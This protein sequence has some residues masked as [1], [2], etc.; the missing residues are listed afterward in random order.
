MTPSSSGNANASCSRDIVATVFF[1]YCHA[2]EVLRDQLQKHLSAM[3]RQ[4]LIE[5]WY[6]R[7]IPA[8]DHIDHSIMR[9][10]ERADVVLLLVSPDFL[11]SDYCNDVEVRRALERHDAG[12]CRVIPVILRH[13][14]WHG[15][16]FGK[17]N[18]TPKDGKPVR[19]F[20]D[21]DEGFLQVVQAIKA[22]LPKSPTQRP[23]PPQPAAQSARQAGASP[24]PRSSNLGLPRKL[25][26]VDL[27]T[28]RDKTFDFIAEYFANSLRE[29]EAR[30][31]QVKGRFTRIDAH[32]F[33]AVAYVDGK[34]R[35]FGHI[36]RARQPDGIAYSSSEHL[37]TN[38]YNEALWVEADQAGIFL[39]P[40][41]LAFRGDRN[42]RLTLDA[43][44]EFYWS[45]F[46]EPLQR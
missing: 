18:A 32:R 17:L 26:D 24:G 36:F 33:T 20:A 45:L 14:D 40:M 11:A 16:P 39:R 23:P 30:H 42:A 41:G 43:A 19:A 9:E 8:G 7:R 34:R 1:S 3:Q 31:P 28:F 13:C 10:L 15:T 12:E 21:L 5:T 29:L 2:D 6:D 37:E 25:T 27:D 22:A 35:S 4:G 44:A 38:G 46:M